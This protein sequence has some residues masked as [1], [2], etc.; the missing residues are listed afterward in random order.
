MYVRAACVENPSIKRQNKTQLSSVHEE[1]SH[2]NIQITKSNMC[3]CSVKDKIAV[4]N[5][6][7]SCRG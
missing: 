4:Q 5:D 3:L 7:I 6:E 2:L 1:K